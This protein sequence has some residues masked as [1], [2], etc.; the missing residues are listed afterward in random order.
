L[1]IKKACS[2]HCGIKLNINNIFP[3]FTLFDRK[4]QNVEQVVES[5]GILDLWQGEVVF[6]VPGGSRALCDAQL[7]VG[8]SAQLD[9]GRGAGHVRNAAIVSSRRTAAPP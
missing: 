2:F 9:I 6:P 7:N 4:A 5:D 3:P 1:Y 8:R